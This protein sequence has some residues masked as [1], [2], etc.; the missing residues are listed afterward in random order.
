M[1]KTILKYWLHF[2]L[3]KDRSTEDFTYSDLKTQS[4][5]FANVLKN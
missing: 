4:A 2:V 3:K 1:P 5:K